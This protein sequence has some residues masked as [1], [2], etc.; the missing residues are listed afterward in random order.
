MPKIIRPIERPNCP[1]GGSTYLERVESHPIHGKG[2]EIRF[3]A[4]EYC[5]TETASETTPDDVDLV[6]ERSDRGTVLSMM[7]D[8]LRS[9]GRLMRSRGRSASTERTFPLA[10]K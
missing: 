3:F 8:K 7:V 2:F 6:P 5:G 10:H 9:V 4:C 1:C